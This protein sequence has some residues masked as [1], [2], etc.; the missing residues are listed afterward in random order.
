MTTKTAIIGGGITGLTAAYY[1]QKAIMANDL[2]MEFKLYE[3]SGRLGGKI[4]TEYRHGFVME[5]GPDSFLARK[6]SASRLAKEVGIDKELVSNFAGQAYILKKD[7]LHPIPKGSVMGVPTKWMPFWQTPLL[8][9]KGKVRALA[10]LVIPKSSPEE[11]QSLGGFFRRRLGSEAVDYLIDPLLSGVYAGDIDKLSLHATYP[12]FFEA[13]QKHQS[14]MR[15]LKPPAPDKNEESSKKKGAFL[16]FERGLYSL[17][18][19]MENHLKEEAV[20]KDTTI[21]R[22][23]KTDRGMML[24]FKD[25]STEEVDHVILATPPH[26]TSKLL[27]DPVVEE[28]LGSIRSTTVATISMAFEAGE[29]PEAFDGTGFVVSKKTDYTI[30]ACTWTH[31]KWKHSA[32]EGKALI[33]CYVGKPGGEDI[34]EK[35]DEEI[36]NAVRHDLEKIMQ[37]QAEPSDFLVTRWRQSMPQYEIGHKQSLARVRQHLADKFPNVYAGGAAFE[38]VGLP[39]CILQGEKAVQFVLRGQ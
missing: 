29:V 4:Q 39:D 30:T 38:G 21:E 19:A 12:Q 6:E 20:H 24:Y 22:L 7:S 35:T 10:D 18:E 26:I 16:S 15:G 25:G 23:S 11:D 37:I 31:R 36:L 17:V 2:D 28:T 14:L 33:R 13:E 8:S 9:F 5:R 1:L 34:V 32:P 27:Q 3:S